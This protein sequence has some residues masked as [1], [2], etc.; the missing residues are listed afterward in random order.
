MGSQLTTVHERYV[1]ACVNEK[2]GDRN[3]CTFNKNALRFYVFLIT[4][5]NKRVS[6][7]SDKARRIRYVH[8][9]V[10]MYIHYQ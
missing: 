10:C 8:I 7:P 3:D 5:L 9:N 4:A 2:T 6:K 1:L